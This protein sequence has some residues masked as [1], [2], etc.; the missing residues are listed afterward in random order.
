MI[1][2][3]EAQHEYKLDG[4]PVPSVTRVIS[5]VPEDLLLNSAFIRKTAIGTMV[6]KICDKL[7]EGAEIDYSA[8]GEEIKPYVD[9]YLKF[10]DQSGYRLVGTEERVFSKK[11]KY[12]GTVDDIRINPKGQLAILDIKTSTVVSP[13]TKL[14]TA[15]YAAAIDE[16]GTYKEYGLV[17]ERG[18]IWLTGDGNYRLLRYMEPG[19]FNVFLCHLTVHNWKRQ[20][21]LS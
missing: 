11:Y 20:E 7:K 16:M 18:C 1:E 12:A 19:D 15:A 6:H 4:R 2:F 9:G 13:T 21:G 10:L 17:K 8:I 5:N 3:D 14:Q